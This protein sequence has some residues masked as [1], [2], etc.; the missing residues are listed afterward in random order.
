MSTWEC[1]SHSSFSCELQ[2][3]DSERCYCYTTNV[4]KVLLKVVN[5]KTKEFKLFTLRNVDIISCE[6]GS[7]DVG[8]VQSNLSVSYRSVED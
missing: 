1:H 5:K 2:G 6:N 8:V 7:F 4:K 3:A